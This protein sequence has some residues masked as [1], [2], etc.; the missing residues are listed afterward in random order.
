MGIS[1]HNIVSGQCIQIRNNR[2]PFN[3]S[4]SGISFSDL[5]IAQGSSVDRM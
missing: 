3:L 4:A 2:I 5:S 1:S